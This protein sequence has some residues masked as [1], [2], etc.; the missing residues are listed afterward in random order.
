MHDV[1]PLFCFEIG[2]LAGRCQLRLPGDYCSRD[3]K[4]FF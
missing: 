1:A 3:K 4:I 2:F